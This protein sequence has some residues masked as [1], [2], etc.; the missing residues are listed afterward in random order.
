MKKHIIW[1]QGIKG[2][3]VSETSDCHLSGAFYGI[4][5]SIHLAKWMHHVEVTNNLHVK[6]NFP[7]LLQ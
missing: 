4:Q 1:D 6:D 5:L 2:L 3:V 7:R